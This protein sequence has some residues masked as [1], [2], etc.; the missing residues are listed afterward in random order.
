[1]PET[2]ALIALGANLGDPETSLKLALDLL[3][4]HPH[5]RLRSVSSFYKTLPVGGPVGQPPFINAAASLFTN[6]TA[7]GL[8]I[9]LQQVEA[10]LGRVR[11]QTWSARS[12]DLDIIAYGETVC[13]TDSLIL[14]HPRMTVRQFVMEPLLEIE[15]FWIHPQ[16]GWNVRQIFDHFRS[17][18]RSVNLDKVLEKFME[19]ESGSKLLDRFK[20]ATDG[21]EWSNG[22]RPTMFEVHW[23]HGFTTDT[24]WRLP[25]FHPSEES[26]E[27][28]MDQLIA[29]CRGMTFS[30]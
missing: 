4:N 3:Q 6:L 17:S 24:K 1:M 8:L 23:I 12:L 13:A 2:L 25:R 18:P 21:W 10:A 11:N 14:P 7:K 16:L 15:P 30:G 19:S 27:C 29:T 22:S 5:L 20:D 9:A 28:L 26:L